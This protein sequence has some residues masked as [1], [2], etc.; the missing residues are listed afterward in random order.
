M[1]G[2]NINVNRSLTGATNSQVN[3]TNVTLDQQ[4]TSTAPTFQRAV[5]EEVIYDQ[6]G[7]AHV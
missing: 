7:R 1:A 6:I 5:V 4:Q 3:L 2:N